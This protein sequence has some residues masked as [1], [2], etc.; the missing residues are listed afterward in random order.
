[1]MLCDSNVWLALALWRHTHQIAA[2]DWLETVVGMPQ[3]A[4]SVR[5]A[6]VEHERPKGSV[7]AGFDCRKG[8]GRLGWRRSPRSAG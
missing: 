3:D 1:M 4:V 2:H 6:V 8:S 7:G 5:Y